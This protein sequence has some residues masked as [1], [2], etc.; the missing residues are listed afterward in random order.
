MVAY[1]LYKPNLSDYEFLRNVHHVTLKPHVEKIW[2]WDESLRD[3]F[4]KEDYNSDQIPIIRAFGQPVGY[5]LL[6]VEA[7][8]T[9]IIDILILPEFQSQKLGSPII[10]DLTSR[11]NMLKQ[12]PLSR[13]LR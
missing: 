13:N 1:S 5:L 6:N 9:H 11:K 7:D 2:G 4:F 3:G 12:K 10:K 8:V